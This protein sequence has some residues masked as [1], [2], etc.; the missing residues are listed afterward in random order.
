MMELGITYHFVVPL[1]LHGW[2]QAANSSSSSLAKHTQQYRF[3]SLKLLYRWFELPLP[4]SVF[5][6]TTLFDWPSIDDDS[7]GVAASFD[8]D[9]AV[10]VVA[11]VVV[12]EVTAIVSAMTEFSEFACVDWDIF[13]VVVGVAKARRY[14]QIITTS[15]YKLCTECFCLYARYD[16][17]PFTFAM[18]CNGWRQTVIVCFVFFF[19]FSGDKMSRA[20][21]RTHSQ[22]FSHSKSIK[23]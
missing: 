11:V 1:H 20:P 12:V 23:N 14:N 9:D 17:F 16:R 19:S 7:F 6:T 13:V 18:Q 2:T 22:K 8:V 5:W 21:P 4:L 15:V 10:V 3:S